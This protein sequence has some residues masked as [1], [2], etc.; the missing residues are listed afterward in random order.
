[1]GNFPYLEAIGPKYESS[2]EVS[3]R[4]VIFIGADTSTSNRFRMGVIV[5]DSPLINLPHAS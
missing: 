4:H 1:M 3:N 5:F 2:G